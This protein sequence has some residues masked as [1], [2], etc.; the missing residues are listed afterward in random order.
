[1]MLSLKLH[2]NFNDTWRAKMTL[3]I[4][5]SAKIEEF[6]DSLEKSN[7][8]RKAKRHRPRRKTARN[9]ESLPKQ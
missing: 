7:V 9:A 1:M 3:E 6:K 8:K 4:V 5:D 2:R